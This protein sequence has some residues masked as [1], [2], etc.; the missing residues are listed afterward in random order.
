MFGYL[1]SFVYSNEESPPVAEHILSTLWYCKKID[2]VM[3]VIEK[4]TEG[5]KHVPKTFL[6][7]LS[8]DKVATHTH[9][10]IK[11]ILVKYNAPSWGVCKQ[12]SDYIADKTPCIASACAI[13]IGTEKVK[14]N[15]E[16]YHKI[17]VLTTTEGKSLEMGEWR[18][19]LKQYRSTEDYISNEKKRSRTYTLGLFNEPLHKTVINTSGKDVPIL[20]LY[21]CKL[22]RNKHCRTP[23][24]IPLDDALTQKDVEKFKEEKGDEHLVIIAKNVAKDVKPPEGVYVCFME[25]TESYADRV[26]PYV[27]NI[28]YSSLDNFLMVIKNEED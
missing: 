9:K 12:I 2:H 15:R 25:D 24:E 13:A 17:R 5:N 16:F 22:F 23:I 20:S 3:K 4:M 8:E 7:Q 11:E 28:E 6:E 14:W 26:Y 18:K 27:D 1:A 21:K 10:I 19:L